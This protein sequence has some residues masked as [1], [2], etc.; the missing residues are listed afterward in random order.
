MPERFDA[1]ADF[2]RQVGLL[3]E[4]GYP[5]LTGLS[6]NAFS[7]RLEPLRTA[8]TR[9]PATRPSR[10]RVP[11]VIAIG[12]D[13]VRPSQA[14]PL[15]VHNGQSGFVSRDT[16][17][18]DEFPT[19]P[20]IDLPTHAWLVLDI[21]RGRDTLGAT[22]EEA[23]A[24][25]ATEG[26]QPLTVEEGIA[27]LTQYPESLEKNNCYQLPGTQLG[28]RVP[29]L[30]ISARAPKLGYCWAGN[31]HTW[32]GHASCAERIGLAESSP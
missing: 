25:F 23:R 26:R 22:P 14:M 12:R 3:I 1:T 29:G 11:F 31:R 27:F 30:W 9:A 5:Q 8:I 4:L 18:I 17:D 15:T 20:E 16:Q 7:E 13:V 32:L 19:R 28:R 21:D 2:D 6:G 10:E 24:R